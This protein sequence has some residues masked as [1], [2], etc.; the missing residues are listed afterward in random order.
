M[1]FTRQEYEILLS[2]M[3]QAFQRNKLAIAA[4]IVGL[5]IGYAVCHFTGQRFLIVGVA[6]Y[7]VDTRTGETWF[8]RGTTETRVSPS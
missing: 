3:R 4:L 5:I 1:S 2:A 8:L 6:P 7:K